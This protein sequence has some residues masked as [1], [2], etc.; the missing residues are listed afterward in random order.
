LTSDLITHLIVW[1]ADTGEK[2]LHFKDF[3]NDQVWRAAWSPDGTRIATHTRSNIGN[4]WDAVTGE[5]MLEF[6]GH[7]GEVWGLSWSPTG[8]RLATG[9]YDNTV[10][11]WDTSSGDQVLH[12]RLDRQV[13]Y[14]D[15]SPDGASLLISTSDRLFV[16]PVWNSTQELIDYAREC[17][18]V[19]ELTPAE[20]EFFGLSSNE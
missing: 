17:C 14:V 6:S 20:L 18:L 15:W 13:E 16:L 4:I 3:E 8:E 7:T 10:R 19:R 1:N 11:V 12:Y 5:K 2:L 9:G